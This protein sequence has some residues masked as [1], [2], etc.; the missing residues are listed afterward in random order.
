[1]TR[2]HALALSLFL[3]PSYA[4]ADHTDFVSAGSDAEVTAAVNAFRAAINAGGPNPNV[5]GSFV[6]GR[7]EI[8]WDAVPDG[9]ASPN[10][11]PGN[12]FNGPAAPRARGAEF[13]TPGTGFLV[14]ADNDNPT[15]TPV[16][17]AELNAGY[18]TQFRPFSAQRLFAP[19]GSN[20]MEVKFF[21]PGT[22]ATRANTSAFGVVFVDV[23]SAASTRIDYF[24]EQAQLIHSLHVPA[25]AAGSGGFSFAGAVFSGGER[26]WR[27]VITSGNA[28]LGANDNAKGGVDVV[29][30]DDFLYAEPVPATN[31]HL[32]SSGGSDE[33]VLASLDAFRASLGTLNPNAPGSLGT[34][35]REINWDAVPD[36]TSAPNNLPADFFN[37]P[38]AP[39]ARGVVFSTPGSGFQ[40]S[41]DSDN[42]TG[43][44]RDFANLDPSY[45][46]EFRDFSPQRLF[47]ALGSNVTDIDFFVPGG[48]DVADTAAFGAVFTDVD[49][50]T[51][52]RIDWLD[53]NNG[54]LASYYVPAGSSAAESFSFLGARFDAPYRVASVRVTSGTG[55]LGAGVVENPAGGSDLVVMDDFI[56]AEPV[57]ISACAVD[58]DHSGAVNSSDFFTFLT[59][60]FS[61]APGADFDRNGIINSNDF[62]VFVTSFFL[63]C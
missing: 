22:S 62:Y 61:E 59:L 8:N 57:A 30:M 16:N 43:T 58:I 32:F 33:Q 48:P 25:S 50:A 63:G 41:A 26:I 20:I 36:G 5:P 29:V 34:G 45:A 47:T 28:V 18:A 46:G 15:G 6:S 19:A 54:L 3:V 55:A 38:A 1:M 14:S 17:F 21:I 49:L 60:F 24:N 39:R 27:V 23:D 9:F 13:T 40:V 7:R 2:R 4:L 52:A 44:P 12:F 10:A 11:F 37:G 42:P 53:R 51:S 56:Y 35:R 31:P